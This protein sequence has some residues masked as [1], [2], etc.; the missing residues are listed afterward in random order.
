VLQTLGDT[1]EEQTQERFSGKTAKA[2]RG[3]RLTDDAE[4]PLN[5][6]IE[7]GLD[8]DQMMFT[9]LDR[10]IA[11]HGDFEVPIE[12]VEVDGEAVTRAR[13]ARELMDEANAD[14]EAA[15]AFRACIMGKIN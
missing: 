12:T 8:M 5:A 7:A 2:K 6:T 13:S 1:I 10:T 11:E 9:E 3:A 15:D 14:I 4:H